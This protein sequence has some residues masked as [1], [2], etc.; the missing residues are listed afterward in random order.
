MLSHQLEEA[1]SSANDETKAKLGVQAK[2]R[3]SE[4]ERAQLQELVEELED[5]KA[6]ADKEKGTISGQVSDVVFY[7]QYDVHYVM[8]I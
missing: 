3:A 8:C 2:L 6:A 5:M 7:S 1:Q 4:D